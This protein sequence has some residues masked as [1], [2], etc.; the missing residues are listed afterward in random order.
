MDP[1]EID[2]PH[3]WNFGPSAWDLLD[4]LRQARLAR[5]PLHL[6]SSL[7]KVFCL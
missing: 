2:P 1:S 7:E 5:I 4:S 6:R 3:Y